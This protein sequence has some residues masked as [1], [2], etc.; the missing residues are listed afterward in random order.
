MSCQLFQQIIILHSLFSKTLELYNV[1]SLCYKELQKT[2][3]LLNTKKWNYCYWSGF[4]MLS[5]FLG[6]RGETENWG[7]CSRGLGVRWLRT[8]QSWVRTSLQ[9]NQRHPH[10]RV[11]GRDRGQMK[12]STW[13]IILF[14]PHDDPFYSRYNFSGFQNVRDRKELNKFRV[15]P[16]LC[17]TSKKQ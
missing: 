5:G 8:A 4:Y 16:R 12:H 9:S 3:M 10:R 14:S 11:T 15:F 1:C 6:A 2:D 17:F 7:Q 13:E